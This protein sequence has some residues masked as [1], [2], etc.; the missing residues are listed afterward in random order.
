VDLSSFQIPKSDIIFAATPNL[1]FVKVPHE[2]PYIQEMAR[3]F[4]EQ[5]YK[6]VVLPRATIEDFKPQNFLYIAEAPTETV[7]IISWL[8][9]DA[10]RKQVKEA[11]NRYTRG[12]L[13]HT[14]FIRATY[15]TSEEGYFTYAAEG[16]SDI[17]Q[18]IQGAENV[19]NFRRETLNE[20]RKPR[21]I[22][23][24]GPCADRATKL[25]VGEMRGRDIQKTL[26]VR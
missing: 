9:S 5:G 19:K 26:V 2:D 15:D 1:D 25:A 13:E 16:V 22:S 7:A 24:V 11:L 18:G 14:R 17:W 10:T 4:I 8:D 6:V 3:P 21:I 23:K 12:E 20:L